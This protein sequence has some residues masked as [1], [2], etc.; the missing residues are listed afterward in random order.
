MKQEPNEEPLVVGNQ[1]CCQDFMAQTQRKSPSL[2]EKHIDFKRLQTVY[3]RVANSALLI[4]TE[5]QAR[6]TFVSVA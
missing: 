2:A 6:F 1:A 3:E 4:L 5:C